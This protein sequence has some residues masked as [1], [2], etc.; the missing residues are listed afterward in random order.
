M[1]R[2][3]NTED[4]R[5]IGIFGQSST[6]KT[7]LGEA[8]L[9]QA[10]V[11]KR[12]GAVNDGTSILSS[13]PLEVEKKITINLSIASFDYEG[14]FLNIL[15]TPGY[16]DFYGEVLSGIRASDIAIIVID[17]LQ[18]LGIV[19]EKAFSD[20]KKHNIPILFYL[21]KIK[22]KE[23]DI[24]T[25]LS[26]MKSAFGN[27]V[28]VTIVEGDD[29]SQV[30]ASDSRY[31][32]DL[33]EAIAETDDTLLE[34]YLSD[35][36]L[37]R[38]ELETAFYKGLS[39]GKIMP[40][41]MGDSL[42]GIGIQTLLSST[43]GI[44]IKREQD[45]L[46]AF[47]F[48]TSVDPHLGDIRYTKILNGELTPGS[49]LYN[50]TQ[51]VNERINQ[52]YLMKGK[53]RE[54]VDKL[55]PGGIGGL[56]KLK[57]THTGD[58]L[59]SEKG[60]PLPGID[61][62]PSLVSVAIVPKEKKDEEKLMEGL[63]RLHEEDPSFTYYYDTETRQTIIKGRGEL[64][65]DII[66]AKLKR[67]YGV[68]LSTERPRI[69]YRETIKRTAE[70]QGK[71]KRQTGG[72]GQ[73]GD[74]WLKIEP[75]ERGQGF[76]FV[77]AIVGGAIPSKYLPSIEKGVKEAMVEGVLAVYPVVDVRV[78]CY[79]GSFH[80]VDSSD[81][82]FKIAGS[83]AFKNACEKAN[84]TILEP[85][86]RVEIVVPE[87]YLGDV[88]GD[89]NARRGKILGTEAVGKFQQ[90]KAYIPEAEMFGYSASLRSITQGRGSFTQEFFHYEEVPR[91][92]HEKIKEQAK[93][94][95]QN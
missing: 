39:C 52:L 8:L 62:L 66:I 67:K 45:K 81:I 69:H 44:S 84:M 60:E 46:L 38:E 94:K 18:D 15:D 30:L 28:P 47:V 61:F 87:E 48:K 64:H 59:R 58:T 40:V 85:I 3:I 79:D 55:P 27:I 34:K 21:S 10:K 53:E 24:D 71:F 4:I 91:E 11:T 72:H 35:E 65:I 5:T 12:L 54:E 73:Y 57:N 76:E 78:T 14:A 23:V 13:S 17:P 32:K 29:V 63:S 26:R 70:A 1:L 9:Y 56:A 75:L 86:M 77:N 89:L 74:C 92:L 95:R 33:V 68:E 7:S 31:H 49:T 41:Y 36:E 80:T 90:I 88:M 2:S 37:K 19:T 43:I 22:E 93:S 83:L 25:A 16:D 50:C 20:I 82:A 42:K 51:N 6:G